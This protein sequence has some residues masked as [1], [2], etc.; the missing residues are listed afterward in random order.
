MLSLYN[1]CYTSQ[2]IVY[3]IVSMY[4][5][6]YAFEKY[7]DP[8]TKKS[9]KPHLDKTI[10]VSFLDKLL[11]IFDS[12]LVLLLSCAIYFNPDSCFSFIEAKNIHITS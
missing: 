4:A 8:Y 2:V 5:F 12:Y 11:N 10:S 9:A 6:W 1:I 3:T 7:E